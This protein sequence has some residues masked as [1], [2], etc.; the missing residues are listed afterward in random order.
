MKTEITRVRKLLTT[1]D[2]NQARDFYLE[3]QA[4]FRPTL[5]D[6]GCPEALIHYRNS[7]AYNFNL[8][9]TFSLQGKDLELWCDY[10]QAMQH[11]LAELYSAENLVIEQ[12]LC[13]TI[14]DIR[15]SCSFILLFP[16]PEEE[17]STLWSIWKLKM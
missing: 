3:A 7:L 4:I 13:T 2:T 14:N 10:E 6:L 8:T 17:K 16:L 15:L 1:L 11:P 9:S 5:L 12:L